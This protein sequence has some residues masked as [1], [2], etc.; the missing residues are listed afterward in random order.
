MQGDDHA[1]P[2]WPPPR[3]GSRVPD[4]RDSVE[5]QEDDAA[6]EA[7][8]AKLDPAEAESG[9]DDAV[10]LAQPREREPGP[11]T[12]TSTRGGD[13]A[14][15]A[16]PPRDIARETARGTGSRAGFP[17]RRRLRASRRKIGGDGR[18]LEPLDVARVLLNRRPAH[19]LRR[20]CGAALSWRGG[21]AGRARRGH[22]VGFPPKSNLTS[23]NSWRLRSGRARPLG[24]VSR[25]GS[26][27]AIVSCAGP[28]NGGRNGEFSDPAT[29]LQ[30]EF[31][32]HSGGLRGRLG[33]C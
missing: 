33:R 3:V 16:Q 12:H 7:R 5:L 29:S 32:E 9:I 1:A 19:A 8:T 13:P 14:R 26:G 22:S 23:R 18:P 27:S 25:I 2:N 11:G 30:H 15:G 28:G 24:R 10:E 6:A 20:S 17:A 21:A 4:H 31:T